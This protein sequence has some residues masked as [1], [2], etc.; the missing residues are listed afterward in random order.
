MTGQ[1]QVDD[2]RRQTIRKQ[3]VND[4]ALGFR[5]RSILNIVRVKRTAFVFD[6]VPPQIRR[7]EIGQTCRRAALLVLEAQQFALNLR[8]AVAPLGLENPV[9]PPKQKMSAI[10]RT[11]Q[12]RNANDKQSTSGARH[13]AFVP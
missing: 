1:R 3:A 4:T 11:C 10:Q 13:G 6:L 12:E 5:E 7:Y 8:H 2:R 9:G